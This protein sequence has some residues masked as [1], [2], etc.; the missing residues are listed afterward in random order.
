[1]QVSLRELRS[2]YVDL[3]LLHYP[4]CWDGLAGCTAKSTAM[5]QQAWREL[6]QLHASG[7]ARAIG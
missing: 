3:L 1:M 7:V 4:R 2:S 6:E 5:W